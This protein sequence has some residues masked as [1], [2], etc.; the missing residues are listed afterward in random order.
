MIEDCT[1]LVLAGGASRRMGQDKTRLMLDGQTLLQ[2]SVVLMRRVF[3]QVMVSVRQSREDVPADVPQVLDEC[4]DAGPLAGLCA[5]LAHARTPW[6]FAMASDMPFLNPSVI[7]SLAKLRTADFQAV[8]PVV[9]GV[10]QPLAAF[11]AVTALPELRAVL[12]SPGKPGLRA[13]LERLDARRVHR[14]EAQE[15]GHF[16]GS[17]DDLDTPEDFAAARGNVRKEQL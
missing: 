14:V 4:P 15:S 6:V 1:G 3:P 13:A 8:V 10:L 5:G 2:R 16:S 9:Q 12:D 7:E 17:F 11:Y